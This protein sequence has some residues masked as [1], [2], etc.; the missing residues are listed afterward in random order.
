MY[1]LCSAYKIGPKFE[2]NLPFAVICYDNA[3]E[4][5]LEKCEPFITHFENERDIQRFDEQFRS[6][7][8][9]LHQLHII[10]KDIK[11]ENLLWSQ[12]Q[13]AYV[14]TDFGISQCIK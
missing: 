8:F 4:F 14:L 12:Y 1:I 10:H 11:Y 7:V 13:N 5:H 3:A 9:W 2:T 6:R